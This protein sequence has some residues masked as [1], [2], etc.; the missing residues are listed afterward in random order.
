MFSFK[1]IFSYVWP[2]MRKHSVLMYG[3]LFLFALRISNDIIRP[4]FFKQI[5]DTLSEGAVDK[6]TL[7]PRL[8]FLIGIIIALNLVALTLG[9]TS[10]YMHLSF[11]IKVIERLRNFTF[12]K[13]ES[14]SQTF[15]ANTFAGSLVTKSRRFV[16]AFET[17]FDIFIYNFWNVTIVL[18]GALVVLSME[19]L[20]IAGILFA[21]ILLYLAIVIFFVKKKIKYD[22]EE[23]KSDSRIGGRL[24]DVF[25]NNVAVKTFSASSRETSSFA[26]I[27]DDAAGKSRKA[28]FFANKVDTLQAFLIF[29]AQ[30]VMLYMLIKYWMADVISTGTVVLVQTYMVIIFDRMWDLGNAFGKFMK[31]AADMQEMVEIFE[32]P[33][34]VK[35]PEHPE[36][37]RMKEG[38]IVFSDVSFTYADGHQIFKNFELDIH[39]GERIG[40]VGHSGAG[41]STVTKLLLRF[42]DP[43]GGR[44]LIDGQDIRAVTQD[45]LRSVISY[46]PQEPLL[47]HRTIKENIAYGKPDATLPEIMEAARRAHAHEFI[48]GLQYGYDTYVGERGVKLSG[49]ERQRIAIARAILKDAPVLVLDEATSALDSHSEA[50]IQDAFNE[51]MKGKT[52]IVIAHRLSTIQ[53]MDRIIVLDNGKIKEEGTHKELIT[54]EGSIYKDLWDIQAGGFIGED[55][56]VADEAT[57]T[58]PAF[59]KQKKDLA[60]RPKP[61]DI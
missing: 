40:L 29:S 56:E 44:V 34:D 6:A 55:E 54:R 5:V 22:L 39:P 31:S 14:H 38:R 30:A 50:L 25:G 17:M 1:R 7:A 8:F 52:T 36:Q 20:V 15:F 28:W 60:D 19:S 47:F 58:E 33:K 49:G 11:E 10:K 12:R 41:K 35:D 24:A 46:V 51:L 21:W 42:N 18:V 53:K 4:I 27:T 16:G 57:G 26:E 45:D 43:E 9:R 23:A 59:E 13:L 3:L 32:I 37:L 61:A 2:H 48:E